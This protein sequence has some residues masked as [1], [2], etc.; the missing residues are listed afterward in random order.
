MLLF[1]DRQLFKQKD[2]AQIHT[3]TLHFVY[4]GLEL[5][6]EVSNVPRKYPSTLRKSLHFKIY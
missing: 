6:R 2:H 3:R 5:E 1:I 4:F